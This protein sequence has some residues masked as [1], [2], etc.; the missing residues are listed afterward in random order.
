M[1]KLNL[2]KNQEI[3]VD[4][5]GSLSITIKQ[6]DSNPYLEIHNDS[7]EFKKSVS[8]NHIHI[9][10][11]LKDQRV[12][13]DDLFNRTRN[14]EKNPSPLQVIS[15][16]ILDLVDIA[17][18]NKSIKENNLKII[19]TLYVNENSIIDI[20]CSNAKIGLGNINIKKLKI[21]SSNM[22]FSGDEYK[23]QKLKIDSSNLD[24]TLRF[25]K[26]NN[27]KINASNSD[28]VIHSPADF[29]G[30]LDLD[31]SH[32]KSNSKTDSSRMNNKKSG[33]LRGDFSNLKI[34]IRS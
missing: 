19:A 14:L 30:Y 22:N 23:I 3:S 9:I 1:S 12:N 15:T 18:K 4:V 28:I 24:A 7:D 2:V 8:N 13:R 11:T 10:D 26:D 33:I 31:Y 21:N 16:F 25:D 17:H 6:T 34:E 27:I 29:D 20:D 5:E 32:I